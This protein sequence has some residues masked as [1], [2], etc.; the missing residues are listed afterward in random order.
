MKKDKS[1]V[2]LMGIVTLL[3]VIGFFSWALPVFMQGDKIQGLG[4]AL[5]G[6]I[7]LV[8]AI[9]NFKRM[10]LDVKKG[11][12]IQ[13]ERSQKVL[14]IAFAKAFLFSIWWLLILSFI[15]ENIN[16]RD[17]GQAL[18]IGIFGMAVLFGLCFLWYNKKQDLDKVKI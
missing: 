12:P 16:F 18:N 13:D 7:I 1:K 17:P 8:Y 3:L 15:S 4:I 2:I 10:Y 6:I 14:M 5:I 11:Y 9:F